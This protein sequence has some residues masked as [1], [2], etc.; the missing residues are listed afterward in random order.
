MTEILA[1]QQLADD[2]DSELIPCSSLSIGCC[3]VETR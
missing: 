1:L 2:S 3:N